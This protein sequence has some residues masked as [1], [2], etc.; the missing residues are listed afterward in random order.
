MHLLGQCS[1]ARNGRNGN[2][3]S[4][5]GPSDINV[6]YPSERMIL[7][8]MSPMLFMRSIKATFSEL[9]LLSAAKQDKKAVLQNACVS[10][11]D[12]SVCKFY[13]QDP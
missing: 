6:T 13:L 12:G 9:R 3:F 8:A 5:G 7:R 11:D 10:Q 2:I 1:Q 4:L